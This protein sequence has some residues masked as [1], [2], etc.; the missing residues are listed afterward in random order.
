[1]WVFEAVSDL[2]GGFNYLVLIA[3]FVAAVFGG[4]IV[5]AI[6]VVIGAVYLLIQAF[7]WAYDRLVGNSI[8][9]DLMDAMWDILAGGMVDIKDFIIET[10]VNLAGSIYDKGKGIVGALADGMKDSIGEV[11]DAAANVAESI[12]DYLPSSPANKGPFAATPPEAWPE[13]FW[14]YSRG[15]W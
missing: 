14:R 3:M 9:P 15:H 7:Q 6:A 2:I 4:P 5:A 1:M 13:H 10:L 8:I 11:T 12:A